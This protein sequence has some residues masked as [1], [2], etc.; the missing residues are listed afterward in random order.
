MMGPLILAWRYIMYHRLKTLTMIGCIFLTAFLPIV[1]GLLL[2]QFNQKIVARADS[3]PALIG[4]KGSNLDLTLHA[5]YF[6]NEAPQTIDYGQVKEIQ[7]KGW[8]IPIPVYSTTKA[9]GFPIV[10]TSLDYFR[11][12]KLTVSEG[13]MLNTLGDCLVGSQVAKELDL[14]AGGELLSERENV[15]DI[16]GR[17]PLKMKVR[18]VL[19]E[20]N[21][22]DDWAVFVDLKTAW[23]IDGFGHGHQDLTKEREKGDSEKL[24]KSNDDTMVANAAVL[25]FTEITPENIGSFHFH[26]DLGDF[27]ITAIIAVAPDVKNETILQ[28]YYETEKPNAQ[29]AKPSVV[30]RELMSIVFQVKKFFDANAVLI[31]VSTSLLLFLVILLSLKLRHRE[32]QTMSKIGC[33]RGTLAMLQIGELGFIFTFAGILLAAAV[34]VVWRF[35]GDIVQALLL[36]S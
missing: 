18:G 30:V 15:L 4:A 25:P 27:P 16:G 1:I 34:W 17:Y 10:A 11:F 24:L 3:T 32:M 9:G 36:G 23:I 28:G 5:L 6:K 35:S 14:S 8:A 26:G 33:N 13:E 7:E 29:F 21:S 31:A 12:R 22:P 20:S 2:R 19:K